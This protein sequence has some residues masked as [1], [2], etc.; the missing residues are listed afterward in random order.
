MGVSAGDIMFLT[1][2]IWRNV[3]HVAGASQVCNGQ[4]IHPYNNHR[5]GEGG[6]MKGWMATSRPYWQVQSVG[7]SRVGLYRLHDALHPGIDSMTCVFQV[8]LGVIQWLAR[9]HTSCIHDAVDS[10]FCSITLWCTLCNTP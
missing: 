1:R 5:T 4:A 2:L 8:G 10:A 3:G 9:E 6:K 7:S